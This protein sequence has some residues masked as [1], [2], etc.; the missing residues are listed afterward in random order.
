MI[1]VLVAQ[2]A[3]LDVP[4]LTV[5]LAIAQYPVWTLPVG[6]ARPRGRSRRRRAPSDATRDPC[7]LR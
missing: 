5:D 2:A 6:D 1:A 7:L 4:I 3:A